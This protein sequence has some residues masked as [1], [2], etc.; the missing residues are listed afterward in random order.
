MC[1]SLPLIIHWLSWKPRNDYSILVGKDNILDIGT[2][3]KL[4]LELV[5]VLK[6][7]NIIFLYKEKAQPIR[8]FVC[9]QWR[10]SEELGLLGMLAQEWK[11][12]VREIISVGV[13]LG[14]GEDCLLWT[15]G[16]Q[17]GNLGKECI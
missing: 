4:S 8:D 17:S 5:H 6:I 3:T 9:A 14:D 10:S 11:T 7:Q 1:K 16:D 12:Y 13:Q 2:P 15:C